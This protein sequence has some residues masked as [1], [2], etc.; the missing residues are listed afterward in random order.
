MLDTRWDMLE[1]CLLPYCSDAYMNDLSARKEI[2][3][4]FFFL[5]SINGKKFDLSQWVCFF[6]T[7]RTAPQADGSSTEKGDRT[8]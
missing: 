8:S 3:F 6:F 2:L 7:H 1:T 4:F 5:N